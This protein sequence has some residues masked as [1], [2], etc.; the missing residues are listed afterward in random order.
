V[1]AADS[2]DLYGNAQA[3]VFAHAVTANPGLELMPF[4][5]EQAVSVTTHRFGTPFDVA[6]EVVATL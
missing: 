1:V 4:L 5:R 6:R 3:A 2:G